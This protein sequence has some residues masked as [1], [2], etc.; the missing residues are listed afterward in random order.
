METINYVTD[1][2]FQLQKHPDP[3]QKEK[4]NTFVYF[5]ADSIEMF[6]EHDKETSPEFQKW[7]AS[8]IKFTNS[9]P[10]VLTVLHS[11]CSRSTLPIKIIQLFTSG[12]ADPNAQCD[13]GNSPLHLLAVSKNFSNVAEATKLLL[14]VGAHL[15]LSNKV[16]K[17]H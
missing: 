11:I 13:D 12:K 2:V 9:H 6:T 17:M 4:S 10:G 16:A 14:D 3:L 1:L 15:D 7:L 8:Y 5:I